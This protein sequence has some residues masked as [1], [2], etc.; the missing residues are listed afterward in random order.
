MKKISKDFIDYHSNNFDEF[1]D[2]MVK[3]KIDKIIASFQEGKNIIFGGD[4][5]IGK[6][7][8]MI[9]LLGFFNLDFDKLR[10]EQ[11]ISAISNEEGYV[12]SGTHLSTNLFIDDIAREKDYYLKYGERIIPFE[13]IVYERE[14]RVLNGRFFGTTRF[15][16]DELLSR[17]GANVISRM[18]E[19]TDFYL[20]EGEDL[21]L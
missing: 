19:N 10:A 9:S 14:D 18:M 20:L 15:T 11:M 6:T 16:I 2:K 7:K 21:R 3:S 1:N 5:G 12:L 4:T 8:L 13:Q 17:Y